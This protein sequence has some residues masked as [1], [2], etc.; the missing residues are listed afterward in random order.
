[1]NERPD[2][3]PKVAGF[4]FAYSIHFSPQG[5]SRPLSEAAPNLIGKSFGSERFLVGATFHADRAM[6]EPTHHRVKLTEAATHKEHTNGTI[7]WCEAGEGPPVLFLHGLGGGRS[8]WGPQLRGLGDSFRCIAWDMPGYGGS[9]PLHPLSF[10]RIAA[11]ITKFLDHLALPQVDLVGLSFGGIHA[12]HT[13]LRYPDRVR[14]LVLADSSPAFG[15]DGT[16][17][18]DWVKS[19]LDALDRGETPAIAGPAIID[20]ITANPLAGQI[21]QELLSSFSQIPVDGFRAAVHCL[22]D[23]DVRGRLHEVAHPTCVI[24]GEL[25]EETP[26][27]YSQA[28]SDGLPNA[29]LHVLDGVGHLTPSEAPDVFNSIVSA[30]LSHD[31]TSAKKDPCD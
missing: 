13:A 16:T 25:D 17:R 14:R 5:N 23:H 18:E 3:G 31:S 28:L 29:Q 26:V 24:V 8:A 12:V 6:T 2:L 19:R 15:M 9:A 1:M 7:A 4:C 30:F 22:P 21:R 20:A 10:E 11:A 27:S